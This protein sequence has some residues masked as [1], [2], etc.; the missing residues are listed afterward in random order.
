[1]APFMQKE[2]GRDKKGTASSIK[3]SQQMMLT[4]VLLLSTWPELNQRASFLFTAVCAQVKLRGLVLRKERM[5]IGVQQT[6]SLPEPG[7]GLTILQPTYAYLMGL[8]ATPGG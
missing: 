2:G 6:L 1:M 7:G 4:P 5:G 8:F 3:D